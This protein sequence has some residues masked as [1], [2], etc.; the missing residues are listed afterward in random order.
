MQF[1]CQTITTVVGS[2]KCLNDYIAGKRNWSFGVRI[3][4]DRAVT[5]S[6]QL[7]GFTNEVKDIVNVSLSSVSPVEKRWPAKKTSAELSDVLQDVILKHTKDLPL[8]HIRSRSS[9]GRWMQPA[10]VP[11]CTETR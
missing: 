4:A 2:F 10:Q 6:T 5:M 7:S 9:V 11:F 3:G 8:T 1:C